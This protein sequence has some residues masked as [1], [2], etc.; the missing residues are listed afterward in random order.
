MIKRVARKQY[1]SK[2]C[3]VCGLDN[4]AGTKAEF[5]DLEDGSVAGLVIPKP[6]HQS[7]PNWIHGGIIT[8][9]LDEVIGR[10]IQNVEHD[11]W[12]VTVELNTKYKKPVPYNE[13][14]ILYGEITENKKKV[15]IG[16]GKIIL[17]DGTIAATATGTY[18]KNI[19]ALSECKDFKEQNKVINRSSDPK[20]FDIPE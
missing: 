20:E 19:K 13:P 11:S 15:F 8:A 2:S 18:V 7:Y 4:E 6:F 17:Q 16:D 12:G 9:L 1:N 14:I 5:Y 3:F 10:S